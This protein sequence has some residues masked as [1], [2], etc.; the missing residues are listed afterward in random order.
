MYPI[1]LPPGGGFY[2]GPAR[3]AGTEIGIVLRRPV[4][5]REM[6][7]LTKSVMDLIRTGM[8]LVARVPVIG[9][10]AGVIGKGGHMGPL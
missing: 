3:R 6:S 4:C 9:R 8:A 5:G 1:S 2:T 10:L 7:P